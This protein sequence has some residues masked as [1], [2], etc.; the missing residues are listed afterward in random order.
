MSSTQVNLPGLNLKKNLSPL[1]REGVS[2]SAQAFWFL[3]A[4]LQSSSLVGGD[5]GALCVHNLLVC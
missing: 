1:Q 3:T 2:A 5:G 4:V